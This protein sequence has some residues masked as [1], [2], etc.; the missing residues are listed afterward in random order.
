MI[1]LGA[2]ERRDSERRDP[3][4]SGGVANS[5]RPAAPPVPDPEVPAKAQRRKFTV[6]YKL[7]IVDEASR[8]TY[9]CAVGPC[10]GAKDCSRSA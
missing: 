7:E 10:C 1:G 6:A 9:P 4:R 2:L 8:A 5:I 3:S